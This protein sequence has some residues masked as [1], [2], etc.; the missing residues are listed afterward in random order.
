[1]NAHRGIV[2]RHGLNGWVFVLGDSLVRIREG[3]HFF[4]TRALA[5]S[6]ARYAGIEVRRDG[7]CHVPA[8]PTPRD[9]V[10]PM[11]PHLATGGA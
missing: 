1:M 10:E 6:Q 4:R 11:A 3:G 2:L 5:V 7:T 9:A 8:Q